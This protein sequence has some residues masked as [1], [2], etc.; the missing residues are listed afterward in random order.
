MAHSKKPLQS[1][2][3]VAENSGG[4]VVRRVL[5][6]LALGYFSLM[7]LDRFTRSKV[8]ARVPPVAVFFAQISGLFPSA[9][10]NSIDYRAEGWLCREGRYVELEMD[11]LFPMLAANKENRFYRIMH[12]YRRNRL[13]ITELDSFIVGRYPADAVAAGGDR[14]G[15]VRLLS[16]RLPVPSERSEVK[17]YRR[18]PLSEYPS[19]QRIEWYWTPRRK[20][21]NRCAGEA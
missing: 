1:T 9:A 6:V 14:L 21:E 13:V 4:R 19:E 20:L 8:N 16:L 12:F 7:I 2:P 3:Y 10:V 11:R 15:G 5:I 18:R 17:R